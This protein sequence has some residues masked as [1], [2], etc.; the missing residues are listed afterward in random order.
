MNIDDQ[1]VFDERPISS[2]CFQ[3]SGGM[4]TI[5]L[6]LYDTIEVYQELDNIGLNST[7]ETWFAVS[8]KGEIIHRINKRYVSKITYA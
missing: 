5:A 6:D 7:T 2:L 3:D 1:S 4:K 8:R